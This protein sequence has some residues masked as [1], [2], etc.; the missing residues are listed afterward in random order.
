METAYKNTNTEIWREKPGDY[1]GDSIH[2]T[3]F[4]D[5]GI[6]CKGHVIVAPVQKW[7]DCG[8]KLLCVDPALPAWRYRLAMK[9]L[10]WN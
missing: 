6:N 10:R 8:E 9:L 4:G 2:V 7:H 3:E 1:Y 5:I